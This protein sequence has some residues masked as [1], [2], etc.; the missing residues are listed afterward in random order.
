M[1]FLILEDDPVDSHYITKIL[2]GH[3]TVVVSSLEN[4]P[5]DMTGY[6]F[7]ICDYFVNGENSKEFIQKL[8]NTIPVILVSGQ[9]DLIPLDDFTGKNMMVISKGPGLDSLLLHYV[10]LLHSEDSKHDSKPLSLSDKYD[11]K[12]LFK[13]LVHDL[14]NDLAKC[15]SYKDLISELDS[16]AQLLF[17]K[18]A[19]NA[20]VF[21]HDRLDFLIKFIREEVEYISLQDVVYHLRKEEEFQ[22]VLKSAVFS[23]DVEKPMNGMPGYFFS[24]IIK[25]FLENTQKYSAREHSL[26]INMNVTFLPDKVILSYQ[27]NGIGMNAEKVEKLFKELKQSKDGAGIGLKMVGDILHMFGAKI[28]VSSEVGKGTTYIITMPNNN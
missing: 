27:D 19:L 22:Q 21:A 2:D 15:V 3:D 13:N 4:V 28:K 11:Y 25:N 24:S 16:S 8:A 9:I 10:N 17:L 12:L 26:V 5:K 1:K 14:R 20:S 7:C 23:G 18:K 6:D